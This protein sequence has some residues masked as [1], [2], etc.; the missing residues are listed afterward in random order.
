MG[1]RLL[2]Q[3]IMYLS[4]GIIL[5]IIFVKQARSETVLV[6][7]IAL[8]EKSGNPWFLIDFNDTLFFTAEDGMAAI[9]SSDGTAEGTGL[10]KQFE[11]DQSGGD[12]GAFAVAFG[13]LYFRGTDYA[14]GT[15]L[16][17]SDG[18]P[19]GTVLTRDI[20][21]GSE[22]GLLGWPSPWRGNVLFVANDGPGPELWTSDGSEAGTQPFVDDALS[23]EAG[24][25]N[26]WD[27]RDGW[28]F[29]STD[30]EHG[31]EL[32]RTDG[33][34]GNSTLVKD[35]VPGPEG[36]FSA[37]PFTFAQLGNDSGVFFVRYADRTELWRTDGTGPGTQNVW[38]L[39]GNASVEP[40]Y[41]LIAYN[42]LVL[43]F[44][45][46]PSHELSLWR[47]D[48]TADGTFLVK[49][50]F[51][52]EPGDFIEYGGLLYI[53]LMDFDRDTG[54]ELWRTDGSGAGT[55][56]FVDL[57]PGTGSAS[58]HGLT[59]YAGGLYF[60][61]DDGTVGEELFLTDGTVAGTKLVADIY[62]GAESSQPD[63]L[64]VSQ[65]SLFFDA[66]EPEH[67]RELYR[68]TVSTGAVS[69][70]GSVTAPEGTALCAMVLASGKFDFSCNPDRSFALQD[71][72]READGTI[73]RQVYADGFFP[74][75]DVLQGSS[76]GTIVL[77]RSGACPDYNVPYTPVA[78][79][80]S[81][82]K[83]VAIRGSILLGNSGTP[84]CAMVL[85]NGAYMFSCDGSGNY[86]LS[87]PLDANGQFKLQ[88]YA[89]GFAPHTA[90]FDETQ[91][92]NDVRM[93]RAVEC[94]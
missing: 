81:A 73:K 76:S 12:P 41:K 65:G 59:R 86:A 15:E 9:Q 52:D 39:P 78:D 19:G 64:T 69:L 82:G 14:H 79:P 80:S 2:L 17:V 10:F 57:N 4:I 93:A 89:D 31:A 62:P 34:A 68:T 33:V 53:A 36:S 30:A 49:D 28:L 24:A 29:K 7:D 72:P 66:Y 58:P 3:R 46:G 84:L 63:Q 37:D 11:P 35:I 91:T 77:Q 87:V 50:G 13:K 83:Y 27:F 51:F 61:A 47:T 88:V 70:S 42:D 92:V 54:F 23:V 25:R 48:G 71:L 8:G 6:K 74:R 85:A 20:W 38:T 94:N 18:S 22:R 5:A 60:V 55:Q 45:M 44:L 56:L 32:W 75:I 67:G 43:F 26:F 1:R 16:W 90:R 21:P 40:Y